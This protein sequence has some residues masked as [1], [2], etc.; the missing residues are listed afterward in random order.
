MGPIATLKQ[1]KRKGN[2]SLK[3]GPYR[4]KSVQAQAAGR[5]IAWHSCRGYLCT[6]PHRVS[7][8]GVLWEM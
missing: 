8:W 7:L 3:E 2:I 1:R 4:N 6:E 5:A